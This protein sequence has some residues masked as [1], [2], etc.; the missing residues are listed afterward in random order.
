MDPDDVDV[1]LDHPAAGHDEAGG[2]GRA[3]DPEADEAL[4]EAL[5]TGLDP[6]IEIVE[7][8]TDINDPEFA[9]AMAARLD[10]LCR[11]TGRGGVQGGES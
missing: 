8:D 1:D 11:A 7:M 9:I 3:H 10:E 6:R 2:H 5:R 4:F